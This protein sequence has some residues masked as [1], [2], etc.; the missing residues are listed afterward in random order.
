MQTHFLRV[1]VA[2]L[3]NDAIYGFYPES[4]C[5]INLAIQKV[6]AFSDS[7]L[8]APSPSG[9]RAAKQGGSLADQLMGPA[10]LKPTQPQGILSTTKNFLTLKD[11]KS[12]VFAPGPK[13][14][15]GDGGRDDLMSQIRNRNVSDCLDVLWLRFVSDQNNL[16]VIVFRRRYIILGEPKGC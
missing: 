1:F 16:T 13:P 11:I 2:N 12:T 15:C 8:P 5:D 6:F 3:K 7:G 9:A 10:N 4:F 14:A